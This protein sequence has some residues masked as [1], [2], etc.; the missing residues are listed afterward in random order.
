MGSFSRVAAL[1]GKEKFS[2]HCE[3]LTLLGLGRLCN[4]YWACPEA[5][6]TESLAERNAGKGRILARRSGKRKEKLYPV[7]DFGFRVFGGLCF[8]LSEQ[9]ARGSVTFWAFDRFRRD[10]T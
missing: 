9:Q 2:R 5:A 6:L 1:R 4:C 8:A 10:M 7:L 3:G